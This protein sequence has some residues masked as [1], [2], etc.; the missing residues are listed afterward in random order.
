MNETILSLLQLTSPSLPLGAYSYS[1]GLES[2]ITQGAI[3]TADSL[4][5]WLKRELNYGA[6][7]LEAA[8]MLRAYFSLKVGDVQAL[9]DWNSWSSAAKESSELRYQSWQMGTS[10]LRLL[11]ELQPQTDKK[12][13]PI[14]QLVQIFG[15]QCNYCV[16]FGIG[17]ACWQLSSENALLG[18]LQSWTANLISVG[19]RVIPFGQTKGQKLLF[20]LNQDIVKA[21]TTIISLSDDDLCNCSFGLGL[22][23]MTHQH[24]HVRLFRS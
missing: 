6:I 17:A 21:T 24:Q 14:E 22:A 16:A 11:R 19:V 7:R 15:R 5:L 20:Q 3:S 23:S 18:Y 9:D 2:L 1:E 12:L 8:I 13:L 4:A 10:L